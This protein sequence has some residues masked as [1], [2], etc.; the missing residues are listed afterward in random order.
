MS[1][2]AK[3]IVVEIFCGTETPILFP[4]HVGHGDMARSLSITPDDVLAAGFVAFSTKERL[5]CGLPYQTVEA[6]AYGESTSLKVQSREEDSRLI[7]QAMKI[8][9]YDL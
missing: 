8:G 3:Y 1:D 7:S 2:R 6:K 4:P 5:H 9:E